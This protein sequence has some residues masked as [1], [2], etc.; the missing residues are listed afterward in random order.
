[1]ADLV[2]AVHDRGL[3]VG[4]YSSAGTHTCQRYPASLGRERRHAEQFASWGIDYLKYDNCGDH[5]GRDALDRYAA[6]G[7][8]LD[9]VD[10]DIVDRMASLDIAAFHG[11]GGWNDPDMLHVGNGPQSG[12]S[13]HE[14][15][16]IDRPLNERETR[17][18]VAFWCL[19]NAPL[20]VGTDLRS[21]SATDRDVLTNADLIAIDQDP[22]GLQ[23]TPDRR[24]DTE[25]IWSKRLH[26]GSA[27]VGLC[28]PNP[29]R[30]EIRTT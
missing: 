1:M 10:R 15:T 5:R 29:D 4:R 20:F 11:P 21:L 22:L 23:A 9:A 6:M 26:D 14:P 25:G 16:V 8:A 30:R 19:W 7:R 2:A 3:R 27:A 18:H 17:T 28:N 24:T 12:Q 13:Q